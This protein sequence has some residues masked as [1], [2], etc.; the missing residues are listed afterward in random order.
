MSGKAIDSVPPV[1]TVRKVTR[2]IEEIEGHVLE[3]AA[4]LLKWKEAFAAPK[5]GIAVIFVTRNINL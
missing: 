4:S 5:L 2:R 1:G 3:C